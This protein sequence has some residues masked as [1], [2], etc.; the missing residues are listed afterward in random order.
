MNSD[1]VAPRPRRPTQDEPESG[2]RSL[3]WLG[4]GEVLVADDDPAMRR[5]LIRAFERFGLTPVPCVDGLEAAQAVEANPDRFRI[6]VLDLT[7]PRMSGDAALTRIRA[8]NAT[9]PAIVLSGYLEDEIR[10]RVNEGDR[11]AVLNK[12]FSLREL[13]DVLWKVA[14]PRD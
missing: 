5:V 12:P 7:M 13:A 3:P 6:V 11:V 4:T 8:A 14:G 10:E 1:S 2:P 9:L